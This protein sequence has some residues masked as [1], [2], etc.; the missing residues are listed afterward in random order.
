MTETEGPQSGR[1]R[2]S[3]LALAQNY[4]AAGMSAKPKELPSGLNRH[5]SRRKV[6][7]KVDTCGGLWVPDPRTGIYYPKGHEKVME[8]VPNGAA[9]LPST[10]WLRS[11]E[12][13]DKSDADF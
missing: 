11:I 5:H 2:M 7:Y 3:K 4:P 6:E 9:S 8:D 12:G 1:R 10:Y 13:V